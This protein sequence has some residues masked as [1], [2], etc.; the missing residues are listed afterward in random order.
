MLEIFDILYPVITELLILS[1]SVSFILEI[2]YL[3]AP[4]TNISIW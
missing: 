4:I 2:A 1:F 3:L